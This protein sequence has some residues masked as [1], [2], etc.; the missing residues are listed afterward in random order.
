MTIMKF[1][2]LDDV[3]SYHPHDKKD[4]RES[5]HHKYTDRYHYL[6]EL[7]DK[8]FITDYFFD[9]TGRSTDE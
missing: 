9:R 1:V 3:N 8:T 4:L 2:I 6:D 5:S 7:L